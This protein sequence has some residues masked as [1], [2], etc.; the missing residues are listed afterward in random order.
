M[1]YETFCELLHVVSQLI[2][3]HD[4]VMRQ[5]ISEFE[6]LSVTCG[7]LPLD[8]SCKDLYLIRGER[9]EMLCDKYM[10]VSKILFM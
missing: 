8:D 7:F 5:S 2:S 10:K 3:K 1:N 9:S 4:S 6:R